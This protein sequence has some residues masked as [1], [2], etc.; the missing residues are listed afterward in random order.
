MPQIKNIDIAKADLFT[1]RAELETK[2][3]PERVEHLI[4]LREMYQWT[5]DNPEARDRQ[6]INR[7][8]DRFNLGLTVLYADLALIKALLPALSDASREFH[9]HRFN[10]M[11]LETYAMAK[12][13]KD[14][15]T[16]EKAASS[17]AKFNRVDLDDEQKFPFELYAKQ[18]Y[19]ATDDPRVLDPTIKILSPEEKARIFKR[20]EMENPDMHDIQYEDVDII[21]DTP[22]E[23]PTS[24]A[25]V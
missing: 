3:A 24:E 14:T 5:L 6:F 7:F 21:E 13:R 17:Y 18:A 12:A 25:E 4:R 23:S 20:Y 10:E 19:I 16:M 8:R 22:T 9:R 11:I 2:Y 15:K 1:D